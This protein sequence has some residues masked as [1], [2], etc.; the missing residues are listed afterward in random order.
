MTGSDSKKLFILFIEGTNNGCNFYRIRQPCLA[1]QEHNNFAV[2]L[3]SQLQPDELETWIDKADVIFT[4]KSSVKFYEY[5][6]ENKGK[7]KFVFDYDDDPF[8]VSPYNPAYQY[9]GV[10]EVDY[11]LGD[12]SKVRL[13]DGDNGFDIEANKLRLKIFMESLKLA[14]AVIT[15]S[16]VLTGSFKRFNK[17]AYVIKNFLN[18]NDWYPLNLIKDGF[19]RIGYQ[20]G[21]SHYEDFWGVRDVLLRVMEKY[22]KVKLVLMGTV[23]DGPLM[24]F[25]SDRIERHA[26]VPIE[27]YPYKFKTLGIDIGIC[28]LENND[29]N[30]KKSEIKFEEYGSL[31]IPCVAQNIPPYNLAI[32]H[33]ETGYLASNE[34]E[35]FEYLSKLVEVEHDRRQ[36]GL[37]A[38]GHIKHAYDLS[39]GIE[40]Y[41]VLIKNLFS[42]QLVVV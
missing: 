31:G 2:A 20:G 3:S 13:R 6:K 34:E 10:K 41:E 15:P 19:I 29:F 4:Q 12:G 17:N 16:S 18:L 28:P 7:K 26:W 11:I 23:Y 33:G 1:L 27:A 39:R 9:H 30:T 32:D 40:R 37:C 14:D 25:D 21:W 38:Q 22:P 8:S 36:L 42:P 35:W 5:M 24:G